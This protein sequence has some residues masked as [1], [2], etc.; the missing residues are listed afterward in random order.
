VILVTCRLSNYLYQ[1]TKTLWNGLLLLGSL[2]LA[3]NN[4]VGTVIAAN[5]HAQAVFWN[6]CILINSL[7]HQQTCLEA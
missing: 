3:L 5:I 2:N 6:L 7:S 1:Q 4:P